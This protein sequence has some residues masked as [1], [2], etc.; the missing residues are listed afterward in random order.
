LAVEFLSELETKIDTVLLTVKSLK[1][2][3]NRFSLEMEE[4]KQKIL[5]LEATNQTLKNDM[6]SLKKSMEE[7]QNKLDNA[8]EKIQGLLL[9][10]ES[11]A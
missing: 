4:Q 6:E 2:E 10:L 11:V 3:K 1:E 8:A 7:K 5:V 9:K